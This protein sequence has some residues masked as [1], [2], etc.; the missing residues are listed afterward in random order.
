MTF[1]Q[2]SLYMRVRLID[3][4][5]VVNTNQRKK[6]VV[7]TNQRKESVVNTNQRKESAFYFTRGLD[8]F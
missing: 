2:Q 1:V 7:N 6:S 4:P 8:L 5:I 3:S